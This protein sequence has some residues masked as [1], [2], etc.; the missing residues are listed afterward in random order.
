MIGTWF[1]NAS[2]YFRIWEI[3]PVTQLLAMAAN[4]LG[5]G[6]YISLWS[7]LCC[8]CAEKKCFRRTISVLG[9]GCAVLYG[10]IIDIYYPVSTIMSLLFLLVGSVLLCFV[11]SDKK[12]NDDVE[13]L[14]VATT[15]SPGGSSSGK[16]RKRGWNCDCEEDYH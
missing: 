5:F 12:V 15:A 2:W 3:G 7:G 4:F 9:I 6:C 14:P 1:G 8:G 16:D 13:I 10:V 11:N